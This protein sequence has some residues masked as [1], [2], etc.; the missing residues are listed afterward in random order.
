LEDITSNAKQHINIIESLASVEDGLTYSIFMPLAECNLEQY[1]EQ[2]SMLHS[3]AVQKAMMIERATGLVG[4]IIYLHHKL[5]SP[6]YSQLPCLNLD[7]KPRNVL[8]VVG[9]DDGKQH[10]K[11]SGLGISLRRA[12]SARE[13]ETTAQ[14]LWG[15]D[16]FR[17]ENV[18]EAKGL[19]W[20]R[21]ENSATDATTGYTI[22]R[23]DQRTYLAP[24]MC[25]LGHPV[26]EESDL[27]SLGC[28][29]SVLLSYLQGS[30]AAVCEFAQLRADSGDETFF[31]LSS[32]KNTLGQKHFGINDLE[33]SDVARKWHK[34]LLVRTRALP[35]NEA[36]VFRS[37]I[38]YL[39][40]QMLIVDPERRRYTTLSDVR[41]QLLDACND[42]HNT[43]DVGVIA[44]QTPDSRT[45]S[46]DMRKWLRQRLDGK[47][48]AQEEYLLREERREGS[49][50]GTVEAFRI[51]IEEYRSP[52]GGN[53][54]TTIEGDLEMP[55]A[56][57]HKDEIFTAP[58]KSRVDWAAVDL[59]RPKTEDQESLLLE[60]DSMT[61]SSAPSIHSH[62]E[63]A[64]ED[65][66]P[67][68][69][70]PSIDDLDNGE[71][72]VDLECDTGV[73][74]QAPSQEDTRPVIGM[75]LPWMIDK[76]FESLSIVHW[77]PPIPKDRVRARWICVSR[78]ISVWF[79]DTK[80]RRL[81]VYAFVM[82]SSNSSLALYRSLR[83]NFNHYIH[84]E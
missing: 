26:R 31:S 36:A 76:V 2:H 78:N 16:L 39:E 17:G 10:W 51:P 47:Q 14:F 72:D 48:Q 64:I 71:D 63:S 57:D 35:R 34:S 22:S 66:I 6:I 38:V 77:E 3:S 7:L 40:R 65:E 37:L 12:E 79:L 19:F 29:L 52:F 84:Q 13:R 23:R 32:N 4:A 67:A 73:E 1:M 75:N 43:A 9:P 53:G 8:V 60:Y 59:N 83:T 49:R 70:L 33:L 41:D 68:T 42:L 45:R 50:L 61:S 25:I 27:W 18:H 30:H 56:Q 21:S 46:L 24:E 28:I 15:Q 5:R 20:G 69:E 74:P 82:I 55:G 80:L 81:V 54:Y 44:H 58:K 62:A 11:I